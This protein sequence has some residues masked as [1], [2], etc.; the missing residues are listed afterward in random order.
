MW[1]IDQLLSS[2]FDRFCEPKPAP[3]PIVPPPP[4]YMQDVRRDAIC[5]MVKHIG[6]DERHGEWYAARMNFFVLADQVRMIGENMN[7]ADLYSPI[8]HSIK[9][10]GHQLTNADGDTHCM[11]LRDFGVLYD[12]FQKERFPEPKHF[13]PKP[14]FW[15]LTNRNNEPPSPS[16]RQRG[17][18][19][20]I[21]REK[22]CETYERELFPMQMRAQR[23]NRAQD[24]DFRP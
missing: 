15:L 10:I 8:R 6:T 7:K 3:A 18:N 21:F 9:A 14:Q 20:A 11:D 17:I 4:A 12:A 13:E 5:E 23:L 24:P 22:L 2:I 19:F 16:F 1:S